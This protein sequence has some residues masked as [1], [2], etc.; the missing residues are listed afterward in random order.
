MEHPEKTDMLNVVDYV[1]IITLENTRC[2]SWNLKIL[3]SCPLGFKIIVNIIFVHMDL[4]Y[5]N[6]L[7]RQKNNCIFKCT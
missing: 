7:K 6:V 1:K 2:S 3:K 5:F 4:S